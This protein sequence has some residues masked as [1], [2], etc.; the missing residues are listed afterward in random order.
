M[1]TIIF[2]GYFA[3]G[4]NI[5]SIQ[6]EAVAH[7]KKLQGDHAIIVNDIDLSRKIRFYMAGGRDML[8]RHYS[9]RIKCGGTAPLCELPTYQEI[10]KMIDWGFYDQ[11]SDLLGNM[12]GDLVK[13]LQ[14]K[15][16]PDAITK[17]I[18]E[19]GFE[20]DKVSVVTERELR[21]RASRRISNTERN[22]RRGW[23]RQLEGAG[24][25]SD[26][27]T[28]HNTIPTCGGIMLA[29]FEQAALAGYEKMIQLD[30]EEE[31]RAIENGIRLFETLHSQYPV[32]SR[33]KMIFETIYFK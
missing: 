18:R 22:S 24:I 30:G 8:I 25:L 26:V 31:R 7:A 23:R 20:E 15:I 29:Q 10:P 4:E 14:D 9:K 11:A 12:E 1:K 5:T 21:N 6:V 3:I 28:A 27:Q 17:R 19:Y 32:D 2:S 33:W 16:V 13:T